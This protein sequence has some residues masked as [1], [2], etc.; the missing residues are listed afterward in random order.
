MSSFSRSK[1]SKNGRQNE[2]EEEALSPTTCKSSLLV[3]D[4]EEWKKE[5]E[6]S[7]GFALYLTWAEMELN[8][9]TLVLWKPYKPN[10]ASKPSTS[11]LIYILIQTK[12]HLIQLTS[13]AIVSITK[14]NVLLEIH[15]MVSRVTV[16]DKMR[17]NSYLRKSPCFPLFES[18]TNSNHSVS[19]ITISLS[20]NQSFETNS[21]QL[22]H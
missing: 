2:E 3:T 4:E 20:S 5:E 14:A 18:K 11:F 22:K 16:F 1:D 15:A 13:N 12:G 8:E 17:G 19:F 7:L 6:G 21:I 9:L 10:F